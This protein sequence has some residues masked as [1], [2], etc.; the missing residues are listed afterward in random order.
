VCASWAAY[1]CNMYA[2]VHCA[3]CSLLEFTDVALP[4]A[5]GDDGTNAAAACNEGVMHGIQSAHI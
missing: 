1:Q 4:C 2:A 5:A 3:L